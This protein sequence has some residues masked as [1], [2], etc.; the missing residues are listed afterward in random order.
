MF[1]N[2]RVR[3]QIKSRVYEAHALA[4]HICN[5]YKAT[6]TTEE[7]AHMVKETLRAMRYNN[8]RG[9]YFATALTGTR[10]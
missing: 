7:L 6:H 10:L 8:G 9:Y 4:T 2:K 5:R 3:Q 1:K